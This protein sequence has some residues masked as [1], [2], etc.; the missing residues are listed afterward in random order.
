[1]A[2]AVCCF[3]AVPLLLIFGKPS[4]LPPDWYKAL[5]LFFTGGASGGIGAFLIRIDQEERKNIRFD[6]LLDTLLMAPSPDVA[7]LERVISGYVGLSPGS[8]P[9]KKNPNP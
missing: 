4:S 5:G 2:I 3:G 7:S 9:R 6:Q 1:L 8:P